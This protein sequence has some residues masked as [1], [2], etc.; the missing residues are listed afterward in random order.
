LIAVN[1]NQTSFKELDSLEKACLKE[2]VFCM[3][4]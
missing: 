3:L 1:N 2:W 4:N